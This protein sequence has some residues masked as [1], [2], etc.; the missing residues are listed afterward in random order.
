MAAF[1]S[2]CQIR[3]VWLII[4]SWLTTDVIGLNLEELSHQLQQLQ[5]NYVSNSIILYIYLMV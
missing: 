2:S 1:V 5:S 4:L 3:F